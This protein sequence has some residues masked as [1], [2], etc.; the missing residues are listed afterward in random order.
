MANTSYQ[1]TFTNPAKN[2]NGGITV[3]E[4][5]GVPVSD[6]TLMGRNYPSYGQA[7]NQNF[8]GLLENF[9]NP[10]QPPNGIEGQLWY[11]SNNR[12]L[13]V[14][15]AVTGWVPVNGVYEQ[16]PD[17]T[18][19]G[20]STGKTGDIWVDTTNF[21][22]YINNG[23]LSSNPW[24]LVGPTTASGTKT[25][26]YPTTLI[27]K[28]NPKL[29]HDVIIMY[30]DDVAVEIIA[31]EQFTPQTV[32]PGFTNLNIGV[33]VSSNISN[34][35]PI[36]SGL[37]Q[38]AISVQQITVSGQTQYVSGNALVRNDTAQSFVN[39]QFTIANDGGLRIGGTTATVL[40]QKTGYRALIANI[41][42]YGRFD[43]QTFANNSPLYA[44]SIDGSQIQAPS[45]RIGINTPN[46]L[47][48]LDVTGSAHVS[49]QLIVNYSVS[50]ASE[51][52]NTTTMF[53][54]GNSVLYGNLGLQNNL[55]VGSPGISN[56]STSTFF[57]TAT[58]SSNIFFM[59]SFTSIGSQ[60]TP[61]GQM[62]VNTVT[63]NQFIGTL[64]GSAQFLSQPQPFSLT[65]P[66]KSVSAISFNGTSAVSLITT[67][68]NAIIDQL[69]PYPGINGGSPSSSNP[70][71]T[72][73]PSDLVMIYSSANGT[74]N[75]RIYNITKQ[76]FLGDVYPFLCPTGTIIPFAGAG[77]PTGWVWCDGQRYNRFGPTTSALFNVIGTTYGTINSN[78]FL[79]PNLNGA[80][81]SGI[82][83]YSLYTSVSTGT[84]GVK[85]PSVGINYMIKL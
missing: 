60:T 44:L 57:G 31:K 78:D 15:D 53:I 56:Y 2:T 84:A 82:G 40:I 42:E 19:R 59:N 61:V 7:I 50:T 80:N 62:Y 28:A 71:L 23:S 46:P 77:L 11:D 75:N 27:D 63:S 70:Q 68:T 83:G 6:L 12:V 29:T 76:N 36:V 55:T 14:N 66:I 26:S 39:G 47:T 41:A 54:G 67:V 3:S 13:K 85:F 18:G 48:E 65:G 81:N 69:N 21:L 58:F 52:Y 37:A 32:I 9:A 30:V 4:Q 51:Y 35:T 33:N 22:L 38:A 45:P 5:Q 64:N 16:A 10:T 20:P 72:S 25:G 17:S 1:I 74:V 43:F 24:I 79:V 73:N 8:L 34:K 49:K